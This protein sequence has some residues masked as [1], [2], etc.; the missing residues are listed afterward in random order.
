MSRN[1]V[2]EFKYFGSTVTSDGYCE[3]DVRSRK[4]AF[5]DKN[6]LFV[7]SFNLELRKR[8]IKCLV[9]RMTLYAAETWTLTKAERKRLEAFEVWTTV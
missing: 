8:M 1:P 4:K 5:M 3:K 2:D 9:W 6:K 7:N